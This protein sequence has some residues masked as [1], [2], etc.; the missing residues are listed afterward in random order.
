MDRLESLILAT[1]WHKQ[2]LER[3]RLPLSEIALVYTAIRV[4]EWRELTAL[5]AIE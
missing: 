5:K 2:S 1:L 4:Q 3:L